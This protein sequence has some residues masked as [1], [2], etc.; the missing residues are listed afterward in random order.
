MIT[1]CGHDLH[2]K[3]EL[4]RIAQ[5][6]ADG[7]ESLDDPRT[8]VD[9]LRKCETRVDLFTFMEIR[10]EDPPRFSYPLEMDNLAVLTLQDYETW[11]ERQ[12]NKK[13]RN[14]VRLADK[15]GVVVRQVAFND[16]LVAGIWAIYNECPYRQGRTFPH[17][18][19]NIQFVRAHAGTFPE[20]SIFVGAFFKDK[21]IGFLKMTCDQTRAQANL[22]SILSMVQHR[23]KAPTNALLAHAV[24]ICVEEGIAHLAYQQFSYGKRKSDSL[25]EFK[26][27]NGFQRVEVHR[28]YVPLTPLGWAAFRLGLHKRLADQ[29]PAPVIEKFREYRNIWYKHK[30]S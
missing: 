9:G 13:A 14:R 26:K 18:G 4:V 10:P 8:L 29:L 12:L 27:H 21:L 19:K 7:Y 24:R 5:R 15:S 28:Y 22:M 16:A 11:W 23:D 17:Y 1:V 3:G 2:I 6:E 20:S 25:S 30:Q